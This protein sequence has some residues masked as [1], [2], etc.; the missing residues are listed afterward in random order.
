MKKTILI[1]VSVL[2]VLSSC[3]IDKSKEGLLKKIK[4]EFPTAYVDM[5][6]TEQQFRVADEF[7]TYP[8][9]RLSNDMETNKK[10]ETLIN[11][12]LGFEPTTISK[13]QIWTTP[14]YGVVKF[15][16]GNGNLVILICS[17]L[18]AELYLY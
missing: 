6:T 14:D 11:S 9:I 2:F 15:I 13:N 16:N 18:R 3:T 5:E 17:K 4:K 7:E 1:I 10:L 8:R 12:H